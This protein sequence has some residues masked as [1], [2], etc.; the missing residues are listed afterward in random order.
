MREED[1]ITVAFCPTPPLFAQGELR[2]ADVIG[3]APCDRISRR[4]SSGRSG[5]LDI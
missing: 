2:K 4:T 3:F 1:R 5:F